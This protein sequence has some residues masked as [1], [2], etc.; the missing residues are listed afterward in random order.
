[1]KL[2][3]VKLIPR[4]ILRQLA[5]VI[6]IVAALLID[7]FMYDK[8]LAILNSNKLTTAIRTDQTKRRGCF[9][10]GN[11]RLTTHLALTF[12]LTSIVVI[13]VR[14]RSTA[15]WAHGMLGDGGWLPT[16]YGSPLLSI[17]PLVVFKQKAVVLFFKF[18]DNR[19]TVCLEFLIFR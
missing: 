5:F 1:M 16:F 14:H 2:V 7:T 9:F 3:L 4:Q 10:T 6:E 13:Q 18:D 15:P 17:L 12:A 8:V 19:K 11:K